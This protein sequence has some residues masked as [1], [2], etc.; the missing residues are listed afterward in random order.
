MHVVRDDAQV[1]RGPRDAGKRI[2]FCNHRHALLIVVATFGACGSISCDRDEPELPPEDAPAVRSVDFDIDHFARIKA[3]R[4]FTIANLV[5]VLQLDRAAGG[6]MGVTLS[7]AQP[8]A[9]GSRMVFGTFE[10]AASLEDLARKDIDFGGAAFYD[11]RGNGIMTPLG[12]YQ[13]K[14]A[15]IRINAHDENHVSGTIRG[16]FHHFKPGQTTLRSTVIPVEAT[17]SAKLIVK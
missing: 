6:S 3:D 1:L 10:K 7:S 4:T 9:D 5:L 12:T 11:P 17:F 16:E 13:P 15:T 14:L 8:A 2:P